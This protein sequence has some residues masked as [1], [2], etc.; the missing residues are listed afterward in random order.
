MIPPNIICE[1]C[2]L[3]CS[4]SWSYLSYKNRCTYIILDSKKNIIG[5]DIRN[6]TFLEPITENSLTIISDYDGTTI[7]FCEPIRIIFKSKQM[8]YF[9]IINNIIQTQSF[10]NRIINMKSF[11]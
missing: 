1:H 11:L 8:T 6:R 7:Y 2:Q 10:I 4:L 9:P 5:Y 3:I